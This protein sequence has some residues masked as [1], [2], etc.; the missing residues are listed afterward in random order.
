[1]RTSKSWVIAAVVAGVAA[2]IEVTQFSDHFYPLL[3]APVKLWWLGFALTVA[4][5]LLS[6]RPAWL[7]IARLLAIAGL[8]WT[9]LVIA[10]WGIWVAWCYGG[11]CRG[12]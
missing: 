5:T 10:S 6:T 12:Y 11:G 9:A 2:F 7:R 1:M 8:L 4:A 3:D